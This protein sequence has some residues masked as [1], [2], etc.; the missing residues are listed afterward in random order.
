MRLKQILKDKE[1][2]TE[3]F[4]KMM[5]VSQPYI[6]QLITGK[7]QPSIKQCERMATILH[8]PL[9]ALFE[10]YGESLVCPYCGKEIQLSK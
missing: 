9:A 2:T 6:S 1:L 7:I 4:A 5:G 8:I 10:G 3:Q